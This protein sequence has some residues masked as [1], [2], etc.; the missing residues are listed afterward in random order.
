MQRNPRERNEKHCAFIRTLPCCLCGD[1]TS[2]E[3][4]HIRMADRSIA[5]GVTG[6][7]TKSDD[8]FVLPLCNAHHSDQHHAGDEHGWWLSKLIDPVKIA[9]ALW[10]VSGDYERGEQIVS[11]SRERCAA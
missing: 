2:T 1:N 6:M 9:L 4:A 8:R 11:A 5:K 7:G 3:C 10:S